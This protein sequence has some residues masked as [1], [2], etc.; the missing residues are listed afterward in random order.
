MQMIYHYKA[1]YCIYSESIKAT[2]KMIHIIKCLVH[3]TGYQILEILHWAYCFI[4]NSY[5]DL[6]VL[7][8]LT[9]KILLKH[10]GV[11]NQLFFII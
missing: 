2:S 5:T 10:Y 4:L 7:A 11:I 3:E 6:F 8:A 1:Y 9:S